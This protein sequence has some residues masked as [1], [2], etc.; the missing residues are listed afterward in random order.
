[1]DDAQDVIRMFL[2]DD[3][4]RARALAAQLHALNLT[5]QGTE[6][7]IVRLVLEAGAPLSVLPGPGAVETALVASGLAAERYEFRGWVPRAPAPRQRFLASAAGAGHP[8]V[9]FES[10]RRYPS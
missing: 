4:E 9:V 6:A 10:P 7:D 1:M 2:T 3:L 8:I 5:R